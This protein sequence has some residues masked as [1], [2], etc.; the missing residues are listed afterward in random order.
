MFSVLATGTIHAH[1]EK[2]F[3]SYMRET[4]NF[5]TGDEY[6]F[7]LG[8]FLQNKRLVQEFN[9][10]DRTFKVALNKFSHYTQAEYKAILGNKVN[11]EKRASK[12]SNV[13]APESFDWRT[14]NVVN[15]IKDQGQCGS[16]WAFSAVQAQESQYAITYG[17]LYSLS[18]QNIVD[19]VT[20][21]YGCNG[22][23]SSKAYDYVIEYQDGLFMLEDDYPYTAQTGTCKFD[24]SKGVAK[25]Q[26]YIS[27]AEG[28]ETDLAEKVASKGVASIAIDASNWSFQLYSTGIYDE[29][30][31]SSYD[32]DHAVGCVG[33]GSENGINYWIV[34]NSWGTSWGEEGYIRM[35][36]DKNNQCGEA[37]EAIIPVD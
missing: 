20:S 9:R 34:R 21:C 19:C 5:F 31:C 24:K 7:R 8:I 6:H 23:W 17:T 18:E 14:K 4:N 35:V 12:P 26:S 33:Y 1:E 25:I 15:P 11:F 22:G 30:Q 28:S 27:I 36:K 32:L 10:G 16:C 37:S 3:L 2:A 13:K 29:P